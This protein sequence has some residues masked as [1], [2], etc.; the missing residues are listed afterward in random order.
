M[1]FN[2]LT[3]LSQSLKFRT[4]RSPNTAHYLS[5]FNR[6]LGLSAPLLH[7]FSYD[8]VI[9]DVA[10]ADVYKDVINHLGLIKTEVLAL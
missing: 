5:F 3:I 1:A 9:G 6:Y 4:L 7:P 2:S 8:I 10:V